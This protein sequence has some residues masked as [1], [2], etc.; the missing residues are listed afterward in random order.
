MNKEKFELSSF[1]YE[2]EQDESLIRF[3]GDAEEI[4]VL[5]MKKTLPVA[6][7]REHDEDGKFRG[8][9][10]YL[11]APTVAKEL[12]YHMRKVTFHACYSKDEGPLIIA[13]KN[14]TP[15]NRNAWNTSLARILNV[16]PGKFFTISR[17]HHS[18]CYTSLDIPEFTAVGEAT[19]SPEF[20]NFEENLWASLSD[21]IIESL[22]HPIAMKLQQK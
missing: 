8:E 11:V 3:P 6:I 14:N 21:K 12:P 10:F 15:R 1:D 9:H 5:G 22:D 4:T 13:Q 2:L 16:E 7:Y 17:S 18:N 20:P 19:A